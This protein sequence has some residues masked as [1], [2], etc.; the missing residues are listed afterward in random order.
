MTPRLGRAVP[1]PLL[2]GFGSVGRIEIHDP[3]L[4]ATHQPARHPTRRPRRRARRWLPTAPRRPRR[5]GP[6]LVAR[7][8]IPYEQRGRGRQVVRRVLELFRPM[9]GRSFAIRS[10]HAA[11]NDADSA[12]L[13][14]GSDLDLRL[15]RR[16]DRRHGRLL[17]RARRYR[18][19]APVSRVRTRRPGSR[20]SS[21]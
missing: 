4:T 11:P 6:S 3:D 18:R 5:R 16:G 2:G 15:W 1:W 7:A 14:G 19:R 12:T 8:E 17:R 13:R 9:R 20:Q 21:N 10:Q